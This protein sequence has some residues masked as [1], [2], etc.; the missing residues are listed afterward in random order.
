M[1]GLTLRMSSHNPMI[2]SKHNPAFMLVKKEPL[3]KEQAKKFIAKTNPPPR[4]TL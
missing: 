3:K 2:N 4:A 1:S